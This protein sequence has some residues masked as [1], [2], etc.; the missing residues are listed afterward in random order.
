MASLFRGLGKVRA[1]GKARIAITLEARDE[2]EFQRRWH[3]PA[4]DYPFAWESGWKFCLEYR[5]DDFPAE[6]GF[7]IDVLGMPVATFSPSYAQ[8]VSPDQ[9]LLI[10]ITPTAPGQP[11]TQPESFRLQLFITDLEPTV[12]ELLRRGVLFDQPP[13]PASSGDDLLVACFNTPNGLQ[14]ELWGFSQV[15]PAFAPAPTLKRSAA[16]SPI[17][18]HKAAAHDR[19][20]V[21]Q[22]EKG[23]PEEIANDS[24][25]YNDEQYS[26]ADDFEE[27]GD[28][29]EK[30][31]G[32]VEGELEEDE[33]EEVRPA[34]QRIYRVSE[35]SEDV[36]DDEDEAEPQDD[37]PDILDVLDSPAKGDEDALL[38]QL[39]H[40]SRRLSEY[41]FDERVEPATPTDT[42]KKVARSRREAGKQISRRRADAP[43]TSVPKGLASRRASQSQ[44]AAPLEP[45]YAD[46][47]DAGPDLE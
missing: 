30:P 35:D 31:I 44:P 7:F 8:F 32:L 17:S 40:A 38:D 41:T 18:D 42:G 46:I 27:L 34:W 13:S 33:T 23:A 45:T 6:V 14:V 28:E 24:D 4:Y 37:E 26:P 5:V 47:E 15:Q 20:K 25:R 36:D 9:E 21:L 2:A 11:P 16:G 19:S 39:L 22:R 10:G 3:K 29:V 12:D 43:R 1:H